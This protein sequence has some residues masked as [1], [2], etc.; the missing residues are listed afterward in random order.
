MARLNDTK[1]DGLAAPE[2]DGA[3]LIVPAA[4]TLASLIEHNR[5]LRRSYSFEVCGRP[6]TDFAAAV[7]VPVVMIGHQPDFLHPGVWAKN[8]VAARI[9]ARVGGRAEFLVVDNDAPHEVSFQSP[10]IDGERWGVRRHVLIDNPGGLPYEHL[11]RLTADRWAAFVDGLPDLIRPAGDSVLRAFESGFLGGSDSANGLDYVDAWIEGM[12]AID[13]DLGIAS[14][15]FRRVGGL[16]SG[17]E[18]AAGQYAAFVAH[19]MLNAESFTAAYNESLAEY[20]RRR[21]IRGAQHP[22][23]DLLIE[24]DRRELPFWIGSDTSPR[25][26]MWV[27]RRGSDAIA[28]GSGDQTAGVISESDLR[29]RPWVALTDGLRC[30]HIRPR[31]LTL[32]MYA[33]LFECDLFIHGIGGA[34]YDQVTDDIIRRF[35]RVEPPA[36]AC[37]S[38]TLFLP[39]PRSRSDNH[40]ADH[41]LRRLRDARFNPQRYVEDG[42]GAESIRDMLAE[43]DRAISASLQ[44]RNDDR[45]NRAARRAAYH[46]IQSANQAIL[47]ACPR[48]LEDSRRKIAEIRDGVEREALASRRDWFLGLYP[49]V[50]LRKLCETLPFA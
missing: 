27:S 6:A 45:R 3:P 30:L 14:P 43:R 24:H 11:P 47:V 26:R 48:I 21:R 18:E 19:T 35:F 28:I 16:F 9:A 5:T 12:R 31:A 39:F 33:R 29:A 25:Q 44:L 41:W 37:V 40:D 8:V 13:A 49:A 1:I 38:A 7:S 10:H 50:K 20:R 42:G 32:T 15:G 46:R 34:K 4:D 23:P 2:H 22:I 17:Q 36:Y